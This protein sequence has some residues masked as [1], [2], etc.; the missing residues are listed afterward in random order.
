MDMK[1]LRTNVGRIST[2]EI[3]KENKIQNLLTELEEKQLQLFSQ[4]ET[5]DRTRILRMALL[6][7]QCNINPD[8]IVGMNIILPQAATIAMFFTHL[9]HIRKLHPVREAAIT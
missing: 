9:S 4:L 7:S 3:F 8:L 1:F 6:S 5:M 2:H